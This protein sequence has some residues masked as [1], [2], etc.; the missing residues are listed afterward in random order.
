MAEIFFGRIVN[1]QGFGGKAMRVVCL[2]ISSS[3]LS[4]WM[5]RDLSEH[6]SLERKDINY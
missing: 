3:S 4:F 5:K 2:I 6:A 1:Y